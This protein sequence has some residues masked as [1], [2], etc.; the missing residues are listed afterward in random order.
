MSASDS[1]SE[2]PPHFEG[3]PHY[4]L[5]EELQLACDE[6]DIPR[7]KRLFAT[8]SLDSDDANKVFTPRHSIQTLQCL[9]EH[10][11]NANGFVSSRYAPSLEA[12]KILARF[13]YDV[14][15]RGHLILQ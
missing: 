5:V 2:G 14:K 7:I 13:G 3:P 6:D 15:G 10:G 8:T 4:V 11:A 1:D 12:L 9:L